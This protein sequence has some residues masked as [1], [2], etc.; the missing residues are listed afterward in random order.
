MKRKLFL[1]PILS[2]CALSS[3]SAMPINFGHSFVLALGEQAF[4]D[5][6]FSDSFPQDV[7]DPDPHPEVFV[8]SFGS[9]LSVN[10]YKFFNSP[11]KA[12][13]SGTQFLQNG[14]TS[15]YEIRA[16]GFSTPVRFEMINELVIL[17]GSASMASHI[18][19]DPIDGPGEHFS[20][21]TT[22]TGILTGILESRWAHYLE[23]FVSH[24]GE[25]ASLSKFT[26]TLRPVPDAG[27]TLTLLG[28]AL[29]IF[30]GIARRF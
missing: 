29:C 16:S 17:G 9:A 3:L 22:S 23:F 27:S 24:Q 25:G 6:G 28:M 4:F 1:L 11:E 15:Y 26:L 8:A 19:D 21:S 12:V 30:G 13:L 2:V 18:H 7:E 10:T 14:S 20:M 5:P